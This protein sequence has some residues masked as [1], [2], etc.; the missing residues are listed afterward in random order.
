ML[1]PKF[2]ASRCCVPNA[3][4]QGR[5]ASGCC[6]T[7]TPCTGS[8]STSAPASSNRS[9]TSIRPPR[10]RIMT[11]TSTSFLVHF[12]RT[13]QALN[14][15]LY[16]VGHAMPSALAYT[17]LVGAR[18]RCLWPIHVYFCLFLFRY[19]MNASAN[20]EYYFGDDIIVAPVTRPSGTICTLVLIRR[21]H[22]SSSA[23]HLPGQGRRVWR[24]RWR[25]WQ[26]R[27]WR[28]GN[29]AREVERGEGGR[30]KKVG[31]GEGG[32]WEGMY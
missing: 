28:V 1:C 19:R 5:V 18:M 2:G 10:A 29:W 3:G 30:G 7:S 20:A 21:A 23:G 15:T 24:W 16:A 9:T 6:R 22:A 31:S 26:W 13:C 12:S 17:M 32:R 14:R 27:W 11:M 8:S 25:W 4:L